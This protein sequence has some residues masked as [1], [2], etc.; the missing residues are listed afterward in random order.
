M[1]LKPNKNLIDQLFSGHFFHILIHGISDFCF[2]SIVVADV[3]IRAPTR[4]WTILRRIYVDPI[5]AVIVRA[6]VAAHSTVC[7]R[8]GTVAVAAI[9]VGV[10]LVCPIDARSIQ[11]AAHWIV[12]FDSHSFF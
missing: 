8:I 9:C 6:A 10:E 4:D 1:N 3:F 5:A 2:L 11:P 7:I 12:S